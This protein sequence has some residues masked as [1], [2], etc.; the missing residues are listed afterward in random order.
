MQ[1][2]DPKIT[3][4]KLDREIELWRESAEVYRRR[5]W[6]L[7]D[8]RE[9]VV[10]VAFV[11]RLPLGPHLVPVISAC[12]RLD[13]SN[14]DLWPPAVEFIDPASGEFAPPPVPAIVPTPEGPRNLLVG[15]HP[16]TRRPFF[17]VPGVRQYHE[18]PQ[19][20]G[21]S[22]L[23]H[24]ASGAG[25]LATVCE[26]IWTSMVRNL[27]GLQVGVVTLP[28]GAPQQAQLQVNMVTGDI[29]AL[30]AGE[31]P[32]VFASAPGNG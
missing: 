4:R 17:C 22:W 31:P 27:V 1:L 24:R 14:Y 30:T 7:L 21:D 25:S 2:V 23:L 5:G 32:Q 15:S 8:R 26:R 28:P 19:H 9:E 3:R 13:Y 16:E 20:S 10:E 12:V 11:G 18:H 6:I 29:D